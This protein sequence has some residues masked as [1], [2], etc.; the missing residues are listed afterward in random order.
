VLAPV[1]FVLTTACLPALLAQSAACLSLSTALLVLA[2]VLFVLTTA[3]LP[4][5]IA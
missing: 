1:L 2:P 4:A 5:L 3:C